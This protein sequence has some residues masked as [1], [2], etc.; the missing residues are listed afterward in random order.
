MN[1][2]F[3]MPVSPS[4]PPEN[5]LGLVVKLETNIGLVVLLV[6]L[7]LSRLILKRT[8]YKCKTLKITYGFFFF[9]E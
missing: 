9:T 7:I 8:G 2:K 3:T 1:K 4:L 5:G 6:V